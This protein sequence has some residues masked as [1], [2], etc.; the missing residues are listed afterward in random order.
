MLAG[1]DARHGGAVQHVALSSL[2][3]RLGGGTDEIQRNIAGE[4]AINL[5][6]EP[7]VDPDV[8]FSLVLRSTPT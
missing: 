7:S 3:A 5:P 4:R 8:P 6:K 1:E 2:G